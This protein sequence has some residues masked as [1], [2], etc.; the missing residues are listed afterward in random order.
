[1]GVL[2]VPGSP[3]LALGYKGINFAASIFCEDLQC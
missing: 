2:F 1:M 3:E